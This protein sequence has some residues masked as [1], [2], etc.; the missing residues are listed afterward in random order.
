MILRRPDRFSIALLT[1]AV[2]VHLALA[3]GFHLSP[4]EEIGRAH[5]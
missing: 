3:L 2:L 4:D 5:V 1:C